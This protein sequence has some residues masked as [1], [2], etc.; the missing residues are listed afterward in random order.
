[1]KNYFSGLTLFVII[2][3]LTYSV[4]TVFL[5]RILLYCI[6]FGTVVSNMSQFTLFFWTNQGH[7]ELTVL[8]LVFRTNHCWKQCLHKKL[9]IAS[10]LQGLY[11]QFSQKIS[12]LFQNGHREEWKRH[13]QQQQ[14]PIYWK[15]Q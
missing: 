3:V 12:N 15:I 6:S 8:F 7:R 9:A 10:I 14:K 11:W 2:D 1:M 5:V 13:Q 4:K